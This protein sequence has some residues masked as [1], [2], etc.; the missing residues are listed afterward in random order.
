MWWESIVL[1]NHFSFHRGSSGK[2]LCLRTEGTVTL[3]LD[4]HGQL[5]CPLQIHPLLPTNPTRHI[6]ICFLQMGKSRCNLTKS[7]SQWCWDCSAGEDGALCWRVKLKDYSTESAMEA[8]SV[9]LNTASILVRLGSQYG[10]MTHKLGK[11][12][13]S[14]KQ[15]VRG[16]QCLGSICWGPLTI[17]RPAGGRSRDREGLWYQQI[18]S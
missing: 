5:C 12:R 4:A 17:H 14:I 13:S 15:T 9:T 1:I 11:G 16:W 18:Y 8:G 7:Y 2:C 10:Q 6:I 3:I